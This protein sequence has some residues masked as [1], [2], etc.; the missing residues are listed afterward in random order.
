MCLFSLPVCCAC[1]RVCTLHRLLLAGVHLVRLAVRSSL[2][3]NHSHTDTQQRI[4]AAQH[5]T[6][7]APAWAPLGLFVYLLRPAPA[8][9]YL[10]TVYLPTAYLLRPA[11]LCTYLECPPY[12]PTNLR[13][14][15]G[16]LF[17]FL[18]QLGAHGSL[19]G[20]TLTITCAAEVGT[21]HPAAP[22]AH[23]TERAVDRYRGANK[24]RYL[25][26]YTPRTPSCPPL[27]PLPSIESRT[28]SRPS[29]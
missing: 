21:R 4:S 19:M 27:P 18:Q 25:P 24:P 20:I 12:L 14:A 22:A 23:D 8:P 13:T 9:V 26:T 15:Q 7:P 16:Y 29:G 6:L 11:P 10:P 28:P 3:T 17:L 1:A 2:R 5:T